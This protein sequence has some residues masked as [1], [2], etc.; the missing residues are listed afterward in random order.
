MH[1]S[2]GCKELGIA[3]DVVIEGDSAERT[4]ESLMRHVQTE[5]TD[6]W[7]EMEEIYQAACSVAR[8]KAA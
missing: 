1:T 3:C 4:V 6:D 7:F 5:H 2:I 8:A